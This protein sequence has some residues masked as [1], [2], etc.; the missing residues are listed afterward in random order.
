[1]GPEAA[2]RPLASDALAL[3][4]LAGGVF[5]AVAWLPRIVASDAKV[6]SWPAIDRI[7]L[8]L[9]LDEPPKFRAEAI[10]DLS[11]IDGRTVHLLL[12][13]A[14]APDRVETSGGRAVPWKDLGR[15]AS[16]YWREGRVLALDLGEA[17]RG[18]RARVRVAYSGRA[19]DEKRGRDWRG[20][21]LLAA[22]ELRMSEQT[23]FY[24]LAPAELES[25]AVRR[26]PA[27]VTVVAPADLEVFVSGRTC[28]APPAHDGARSWCFEI[29]RPS[30][31][32]VVGGRRTRRE[33]VRDGAR[34][35][36]LLLPEH[37][38]LAGAIAD[39]SSRMIASF[40]ARF[41]ASPD[42]TLG[43]F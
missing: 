8:S 19:D 7:E 29:A 16:R 33:T 24:P 39:E 17:P 26:A 15:L 42:A 21:L 6:E 35:V 41:G 28:E 30:T 37:A 43:V 18:G 32:S 23:V 3:V 9:A 4:G 13:R 10:L 36:T 1:M 2:R 34:V 31:L 11:A 25:P 40:A 5:G 12:N 38:E 27:R 20:M 22:D 14:L